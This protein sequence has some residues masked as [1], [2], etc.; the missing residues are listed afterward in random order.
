MC[1][2]STHVCIGVCTCVLV[3][4]IIHVAC[5]EFGV[6]KVCTVSMSAVTCVP[7]FLI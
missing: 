2:H 3:C 5:K 7:I 4:M 1:T 6:K